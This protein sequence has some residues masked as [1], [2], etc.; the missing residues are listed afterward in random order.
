MFNYSNLPKVF[1]SISWKRY[2]I[3]ISSVLLLLGACQTS[4]TI[5]Q[6]VNRGLEIRFL[7]GSDLKDFCDRVA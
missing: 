2:F 6:T 7:A 4:Q 1:P 5:N 3:P